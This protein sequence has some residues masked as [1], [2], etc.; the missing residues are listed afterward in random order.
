M[1]P[2][3]KMSL[4][5]AEIAAEITTMFNS[6][7]AEPIPRPLKICTNGLPSLPILLQG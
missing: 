7:A 4:L 3:L 2:A 5:I 6:V 1:R